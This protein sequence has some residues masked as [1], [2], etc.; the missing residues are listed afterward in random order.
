MTSK[1]IFRECASSRHP[2]IQYWFWDKDLVERKDFFHQLD[3]LAE[4]SDF[5]TVIITERDGIN[6]YEKNLLR[7][8]RYAPQPPSLN[9]SPSQREVLSAVP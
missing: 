8:A 1:L 5:N 3:L 4:H 2:K 7:T 9:G 6:L